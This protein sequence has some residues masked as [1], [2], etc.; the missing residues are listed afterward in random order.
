MPKGVNRSNEIAAPPHVLSHTTRNLNNCGCLWH[1]QNRI[2]RRRYWSTALVVSWVLLLR[3]TI[4]IAQ[5]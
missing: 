1:W 4:R 3:L 2:Q 5:R